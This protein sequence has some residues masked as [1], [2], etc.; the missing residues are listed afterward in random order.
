MTFL[1]FMLS[2]IRNDTG[3]SSKSYSLVLAAS[4]GAFIG[5]T[6]AICLFIDVY[7]NGS[8]Q[9]DL[10]SLGIFLLCVGGYMAGGGLNKMVS[11]REMAKRGKVDK[12]ES[13]TENLN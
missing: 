5:I 12:K 13:T 1:K 8:I 7:R 9:T 3:N 11:E 6:I 4:V 2:L 10:D